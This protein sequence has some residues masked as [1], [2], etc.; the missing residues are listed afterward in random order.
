MS[1]PWLDAL[2]GKDEETPSPSSQF[3]GED[4]GETDINK[5][6]VLKVDNY[7]VCACALSHSGRL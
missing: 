2:G 3:R 1:K 4:R 5:Q 7:T 6:T